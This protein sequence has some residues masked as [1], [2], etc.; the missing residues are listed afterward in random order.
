MLALVVL[1]ALDLELS[2]AAMGSLCH[3]AGDGQA[4]QS[5]AAGLVMLQRTCGLALGRQ[6]CS[7]TH[8]LLHLHPTYRPLKTGDPG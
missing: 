6:Q 2:L 5:K 3:R 1:E 8:L 4:V 7:P